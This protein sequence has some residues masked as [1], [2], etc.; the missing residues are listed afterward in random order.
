MERE[1]VKYAVNRGKISWWRVRDSNGLRLETLRVCTSHD[2]RSR[3]N[4][5][6]DATQTQS[7]RGVVL[8]SG[9][10]PITHSFAQATP[11]IGGSGN[12]NSALSGLVLKRSESAGGESQLDT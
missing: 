8:A 6:R 2:C 12:K 10:P 11:E 1:G 3:Q 7:A 4:V 5:A 9:D